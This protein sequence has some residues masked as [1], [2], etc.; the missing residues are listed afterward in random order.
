MLGHRLAAHLQAI[1]E[2]AQR[3]SVLR[4]QAIEQFAPG[5]IGKGLEHVVHRR[6]I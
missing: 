3:L 5:G 2:L 4:A 6:C 1:A